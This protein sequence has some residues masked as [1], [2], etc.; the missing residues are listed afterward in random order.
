M[1]RRIPQRVTTDDYVSLLLGGARRHKIRLHPSNISH[2]LCG[3]I[4]PTLKAG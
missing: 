4:D 1:F 3:D 2:L